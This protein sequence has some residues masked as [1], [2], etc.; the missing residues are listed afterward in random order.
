ML[1]VGS[2]AGAGLAFLTQVLLARTLGRNDYGAFSAALTSITLVA[3][4]AG[5][6][7]AQYWLKAFGQEGWSAMR[8]LKP[9]F[10]FIASSALM[11]IAGTVVWA[12]C[13]GHEPLTQNLLL[14][15]SLYGIGQLSV[16]LVSSKLQLEERYLHLALWQFLPHFLRCLMVAIAALIVPVTLSALYYGAVFSL[17]AVVFC[18]A[19]IAPLRR[20]A[21]GRLRLKG[22]GRRGEPAR[23]SQAP[24]MGRV[25]AASWP[26]GVAALSHLIYFQSN[27][28]L[29]KHLSS[30]SAAGVYSVAF[31]VM[32]AVYL[33]PNVIY[34]RF[35]LPK[36]HRWARHDPQRFYQV[37]RQGNGLMLLL[38]TLALLL[39][40]LTA[41]WAVLLLFGQA[42]QEAGPVLK[43]LAL[44]APIIFLAFSAGATLVTEEHMQTKVRYMAVVALINVLLNLVLIPL[45]ELRGA[46]VASVLSN[47]LLLLL[48]V[49]GA[50]RLV[51]HNRLR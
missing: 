6:G 16:E 12:L 15:L 14:I 5:L 34:Q 21:N 19:S 51:F 39:I 1:W 28:I 48:Y 8:W 41:D 27:I 32:S 23:A 42:Y 33:L 4:L 24:S 18:L 36:M 9:S 45:F 49:R 17:V 38:G 31:T 50:R 26:F 22:H 20:M 37:Y 30:N 2:L 46:A 10:R 35:L 40:V 7:I 11:L 13:A 25:V 43:I 47:L 29:L 44:S 3:P